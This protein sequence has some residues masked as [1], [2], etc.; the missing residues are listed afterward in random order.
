[1]TPSPEDLVVLKL[2]AHRPKDLID[3]RNLLALPDLDWSYI[4]RPPLPGWA[5][6]RRPRCAR[7]RAGS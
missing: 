1:V 3:L 7:C 2:I 6:A 5:A 4:E